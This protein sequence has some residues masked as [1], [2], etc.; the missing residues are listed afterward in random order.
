[1]ISSE[2]LGS[3]HVTQ[4]NHSS[5][6]ADPVSQTVVCCRIHVEFVPA[7]DMKLSDSCM[8]SGLWRAG[9]CFVWKQQHSKLKL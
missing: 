2:L 7:F 3:T 6:S 8:I 9:S 5:T 1:L 4:L